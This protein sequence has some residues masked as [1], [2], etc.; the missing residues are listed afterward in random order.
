MIPLAASLPAGVRR[1]PWRVVCGVATVAVI[2][3]LAQP[4]LAHQAWAQSASRV[5]AFDIA[6]QDASSALLRLCL[7]AGCE[8]AF[9]QRPGRDVRTRPVNGRMSWRAALARM[10]EGT[11]LRYRFVGSQG[12]RI[13]AVAPSARPAAPPPPETTELDAVEVVGRLSDRID[14]ALRRKRDADVISDGLSSERIGDL[15]S[16]NLAEALQRVPGVAIE[17]EVGEGQFVSVRGLGPL[18]QSVTLNGAPVA[19]NENIRNSTQ[20]GRQFRFRALSVDLLAGARLTKSATADLTEGGIGSNIDIETAGGLDGDPFLTLRLGG[21]T[22]TRDERISPDLSV[23]GRW[24]S[25]SGSAGL[26]AGL[27]QEQR[28]VRYDRFQVMR[29]GEI[30]VDGRTLAAPNDL[31]TTVESED[32]RRRSGFIGADWQVSPDI[33]L[34][35]DALVSTFDNAIREDRLVFGLGER[36]VAPGAIQRVQDGVVTAGRI[37][38]GRIDNNTEFSDQSHLN[39]ATSLGAELK[40]GNWRLTPRLSVSSARSVLDTPLERLSAQSPEG[41]AYVFDLNGAADARRADRLTTDFDLL[42]PSRLVLAQLN[43][44]AV[45]SRDEDVTAVLDVRRTLDRTWG[46]LRLSAVQMGGQFST[47]SRDYQRRDRRAALRPGHSDIAELYDS[48]TPGDVFSDLIAARPGPW[49]TPAFDRLRAAFVLPGERDDVVF[50]PD[51]LTATGSDLQNS[52]G[53]EER[54]V[55]A[56]VRADFDGRGGGLSYFGN[57]GLRLVGTRTHVEGA[58]MAG[59]GG[60]AH[61]T[62]LTHDGEDAI[63]LPS[64]NL[65]FDIA[66]DAVVRL[67][68]S[69]TLTRPSLADLRASTV[70]ASVLVSAIYQ[71]GQAAVDDPEPGVIFSGIGGNPELTPYVSTNLD[72]SYEVTGRR[73]SFSLALFHKT[74]RDFIQATWA[75]ENLTFETQTGAAVQAP[76]LMSRPRNVGQARIDGLEAGLHHRL[77]GGLGVWAS[78]TWTDSRLA[79]GERLTGVSDLAWSINPYLERGPFAL[80]LSWSWRSAF[81]SEA[82]LQGGG[83]SAFIVGPA[84]YL[85]AQVTY[86]IDARTRLSIAA[87]NLTDTRD[88]A[89]ERT[90]A[91]LLQIGSAGR[92]L[93]FGLELNW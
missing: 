19:F 41:V 51:D 28:S 86:R 50:R 78:A 68:A 56:Y 21:E 38:A 48:A 14:E 76:V 36:L 18:F 62:P 89:Y 10:L 70:P 12:V 75:T 45:Q 84:G 54:V 63:L 77:G 24:V 37:A 53:V 16:A 43:I 33:R 71:Y 34:D 52:Y 67:A 59:V 6:G 73:T 23:G 92:Q 64:V 1:K 8:L 20:S 13:W 42:G 5:Q 46:G 49:I 85:D 22:T 72:L 9:I 60:V 74:I 35:L 11:D 15:P 30:V 90:P 87:T 79:D 26:V 66:D 32:R 80:N 31:R 4:A 57:A 44:R 65:A 58:R 81:R 27:S 25:S 55:A 83:V 47:R 17:R 88:L 69:R 40:L 93:S 3:A 2:S 7:E 82:D 91:R 61:V 39:V 29:Y